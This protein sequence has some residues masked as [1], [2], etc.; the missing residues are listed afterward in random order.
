MSKQCLR[1]EKAP[2]S[3]T[4]ASRILRIA[5]FHIYNGDKYIYSLCESRIATDN[6]V[7]TETFDLEHRRESMKCTDID[8]IS[9]EIIISNLTIN[10]INYGTVDFDEVD[11]TFA[12]GK[13]FMRNLRLNL[14]NC[15]FSMVKIDILKLSVTNEERIVIFLIRDHTIPETNNYIAK[16]SSKSSY[17]APYMYKTS[18]GFWINVGYVYGKVHLET[19]KG[20]QYL[21]YTRSYINNK[22]IGPVTRTCFIPFNEQPKDYEIISSDGISYTR[23]YDYKGGLCTFTEYNHYY[24]SIKDILSQFLPKDLYDLC[25]Y[26]YF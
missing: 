1:I 24:Q 20:D 15:V 26:L 16:I 19:I 18:H 4:V 11:Y 23:Y 7:R 12:T 10:L 5:K 22:L 6:K 9:G 13:I 21:S 8:E 3:L 14:M 17:I 2:K 25:G